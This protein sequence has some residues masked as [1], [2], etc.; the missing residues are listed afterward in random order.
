MDT[1][2]E[3]SKSK[4]QLEEEKTIALNMR[5]KPLDLDGLDS[6]QLKKKAGDL[7]NIVVQLETD[8]YDLTEKT[9]TQDYQMMELKERQKQQ[10]RMRATKKGLDPESFIGK[11]PP[12]M[13]M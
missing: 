3:M 13:R 1:K 7:Y 9:K 6:D 12:K 10:L 4:E 5:V 11:Y 2:K 8:K